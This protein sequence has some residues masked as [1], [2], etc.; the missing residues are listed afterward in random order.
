MGLGLFASE[1]EFDLL[2]PNLLA[3]A[4]YL[5]NDY[6]PFAEIQ[7]LGFFDQSRFLFGIRR[8]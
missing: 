4:A 6:E 3:G 5:G 7:A 8:F 2:I 1:G